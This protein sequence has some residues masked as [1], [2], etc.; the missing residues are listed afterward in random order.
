MNNTISYEEKDLSNYNQQN[1][2]N[3]NGNHSID[4]NGSLDNPS[5]QDNG[6][7]PGNNNL[8]GGRSNTRLGARATISESD[9]LL[10]QQRKTSQFQ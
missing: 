2:Q 9:A 6:S 4:Q 1:V 7:Y 5:F 10:Q 3:V 8:I